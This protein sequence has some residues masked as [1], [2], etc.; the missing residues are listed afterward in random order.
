[1]ETFR[2]VAPLHV[3][4]SPYNLFE[5][6]IEAQKRGLNPLGRIVSWGIDGTMMQQNA[7]SVG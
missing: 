7:R 6:A 5:R 3:L 2:R 1:M 4:Q